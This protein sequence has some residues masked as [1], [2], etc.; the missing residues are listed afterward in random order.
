[1]S[2]DEGEHEIE[3]LP[4]S[5][6]HFGQINRRTQE[7]YDSDE[8][9][10]RLNFG[11][12]DDEEDFIDMPQKENKTSVIKERDSYQ[13]AIKERAKNKYKIDPDKFSTKETPKDAV[14]KP[15]NHTETRTCE[16][17][18][19]K[20]NKMSLIKACFVRVEKIPIP[21]ETSNAEDSEDDLDEDFEDE[22]DR[23]FAEIE[24]LERKHVEGETQLRSSD[25]AISD[26]LDSLIEDVM[27]QVVEPWSEYVSVKRVEGK[28]DKAI[29]QRQ[30]DID[31]ND[32]VP[33]QLESGWDRMEI[34]SQPAESVSKLNYYFTC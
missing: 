13:T 31:Q 28:A 4:S 32:P 27:G 23:V 1:M 20:L 17:K 21:E 26:I 3:I 25:L 29:F 14:S 7:D 6:I 16:V 2:D 30:D 11:V 8:E 22:L 33:S 9:Y 5:S 24:A 10:D 18:I 15:R 12:Q 34:T 19:K